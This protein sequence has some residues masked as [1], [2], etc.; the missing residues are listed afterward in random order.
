M[1]HEMN[2]V[3]AVSVTGSSSVRLPRSPPQA[4]LPIHIPQPE[5]EHQASPRCTTASLPLRL[6]HTQL[7]GWRWWWWGG[8]GGIINYWPQAHAVPGGPG[9]EALCAEIQ[10]LEKGKKKKKKG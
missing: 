7:T 5:R 3:D 2:R 9:G 1:N 4:P 10:P 8:G 6:V